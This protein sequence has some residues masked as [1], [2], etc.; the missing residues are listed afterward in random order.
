MR[1]PGI[2]RL[3]RRGP[4]SMDSISRRLALPFSTGGAGSTEQIF[5][6]H[7]TSSVVVSSGEAGSAEQLTTQLSLPLSGGA[8]SAGPPY[9]FPFSVLSAGGAGSTAQF[10]HSSGHVAPAIPVSRVDFP[11]RLITSFSSFH[12]AFN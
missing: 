12:R 5:G 9:R 6:S 1:P 7:L 4:R 2:R 10:T 3:R 11:Q 8:G